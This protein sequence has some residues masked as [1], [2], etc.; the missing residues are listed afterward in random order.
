AAAAEEGPPVSDAELAPLKE[1]QR[2]RA[3]G[4][5]AYT[6]ATDATLREIVRR[7]P[8]SAAALLEI[9]GI[10]PS[11]VEKHAASLLELLAQ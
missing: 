11:F 2:G 8:A 3:D 10:G 5:P 9:R 7:R 1:W 6:V 4:K